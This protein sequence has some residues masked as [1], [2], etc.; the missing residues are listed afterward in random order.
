MDRSRSFLLFGF[1]RSGSSRCVQHRFGIPFN[2]WFPTLPPSRRGDI[3]DRLPLTGSGR[4][5]AAGIA[6]RPIARAPPQDAVR[7]PF[8]KWSIKILVARTGACDAGKG[9]GRLFVASGRNVLRETSQSRRSLPA[10]IRLAAGKN[11]ALSLLRATTAHIWR[12]AVQPRSSSDRG[13]LPRNSS[14]GR[15][16]LRGRRPWAA[17][18]LSFQ[19]PYRMCIFLAV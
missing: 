17:T 8:A 10:T 4:T 15:S 7:F 2:N 16:G 14:A 12:S 19:R 18:R 5:F 6:P 9:R 13:H 1:R 11:A 3:P